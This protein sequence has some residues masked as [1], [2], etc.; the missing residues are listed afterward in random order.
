MNYFIVFQNKTYHEEQK[1][2]YLWAPQKT[3]SGKNVYHWDNMTKIKKGDIIFSLYKRNIVSI[4]IATQNYIEANRPTDLDSVNLWGKEGWKVNVE[5][6]VLKNL[7]SIDDNI[8]EILKLCSKKYAPFTK[9]GKG[10]QGYLFEISREMGEYLINL[11]NQYNK[12][13]IL[14]LSSEENEYIEDTEILLNTFKDET[15][16]ERVVKSRLGQGLFKSKLLTKSCECKICGMKIKELLIASHCKPWKV[17]SNKERLDANNG[18]LLCPTHDALFD[19]GLISFNE[20]GNIKISSR[21]SK[22]QF[23]LL[24]INESITISVNKDQKKY[25]K[26]HMMYIFK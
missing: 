19:K 17:C 15:E 2:G 24:N 3:K 9:Q 12:T 10:S 20:D 25:I 16:K 26:Y 1:G 5:Y 7:V 18:M 4:N 8:E 14:V 21:I 22:D 11:A 6:N 23:Y 13:N